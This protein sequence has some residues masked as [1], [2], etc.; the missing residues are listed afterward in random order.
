MNIFW[1]LKSKISNLDHR[2]LWSRFRHLTKAFMYINKLIYLNNTLWKFELKSYLPAQRHSLASISYGIH[3]HVTPDLITRENWE[4]RIGL[5][6]YLNARAINSLYLFWY[7]AFEKHYILS[8]IHNYTICL[9]KS[10]YLRFI[11]S[12]NICIIN[13]ICVWYSIRWYDSKIH[14]NYIIYFL[15]L[16]NKI[17]TQPRS[18]K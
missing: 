13:A 9:V 18:Q 4:D 10:S 6:S 17:K 7:N 1:S 11:N 8:V 5:V 2:Q 3:R 15:I 12:F 14:S 16:Q